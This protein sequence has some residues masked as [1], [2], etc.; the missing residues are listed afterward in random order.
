M[1]VNDGFGNEADVVMTG[2]IT[3]SQSV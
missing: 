3:L 1:T 2:F